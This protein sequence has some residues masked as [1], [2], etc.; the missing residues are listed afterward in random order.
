M[1]LRVASHPELLDGAPLERVEAGSR[2]L[3]TAEHG[4]W[5]RQDRVIRPDVLRPIGR[6]EIHDDPAVPLATDRSQ[7]PAKL[8]RSLGERGRDG[9]RQPVVSPGDPVSLVGHAGERQ[10][11]ARRLLAE[12][13][14]EIQRRLV[15]RRRAVLQRV[16]RVEEA[17]EPRRRASGNARVD[18]LPDA[19]AVERHAR[20][21]PGLVG[22][23]LA[24]G[25]EVP[26]QERIHGL[27]LPVGVGHR[28]EG[29]QHVEGVLRAGRLGRVKVDGPKAE[30]PRE[31]EHRLVVRVDELTTPLL[32]GSSSSPP[33]SVDA[34]A[35]FGLVD[36][37]GN[38]AILEGRGGGQ[39]GAIPLRRWRSWPGAFSAAPSSPGAP[40]RRPAERRRAR[41][42]P[43]PRRPRRGGPRD[44]RRATRARRRPRAR[45]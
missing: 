1:E 19:H 17:T 16:R 28:I 22:G 27:E 9:A 30:P 7:A 25:V 41:P 14:D 8:D 40:A 33:R 3:E 34:A 5:Q 21:R 10:V 26:P 39:A 20:G 29:A 43:S 32:P 24:R 37:R 18:P 13:I 35:V 36:G 11:S 38:A 44:I 15:G 4:E 6:L 23:L 2:V 45:G 31:A 12:E 42:T